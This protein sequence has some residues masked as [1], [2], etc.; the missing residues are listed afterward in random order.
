VDG[1]IGDALAQLQYTPAAYA[2]IDRLVLDLA[3]ELAHGRLLVT[4]GGGYAAENVS[5]VLARAGLVLAGLMVPDDR[6]QVPDEWREEF[7]ELTREVAP[8]TWGEHPE[9]IPSR[10]RSRDETDLL[11]MLETELGQRFPPVD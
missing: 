1:H 5:R 6:S 4:G 11:T 9:P 2:E 7:H 3:K 8:K 10:W